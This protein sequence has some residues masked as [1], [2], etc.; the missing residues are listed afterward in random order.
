MSMKIYISAWC[1]LHITPLGILEACIAL[2]NMNRSMFETCDANVHKDDPKIN[3]KL[4]E[5]LLANTA[6]PSSTMLLAV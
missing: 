5:L 2:G 6:C 1:L 3:R 4:K